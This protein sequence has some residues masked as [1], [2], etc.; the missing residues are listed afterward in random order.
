MYVPGSSERGINMEVIIFCVTIGIILCFAVFG[1]GLAIGRE[2]GNHERDTKADSE[3]SSKCGHHNNSVLCGGSDNL[4]DSIVG[5]VHGQVNSR[6]P[7]GMVRELR[8]KELADILR[9]M[10]KILGLSPGECDVLDEAAYRLE[11]VLKDE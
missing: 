7:M 6:R 9:V 10:T 5:D 3:Q 4:C 2:C 11:E 8:D 1:I